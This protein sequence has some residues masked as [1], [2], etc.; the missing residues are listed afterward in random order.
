MVAHFVQVVTNHERNSRPDVASSFNFAGFCLIL[1]L[2]VGV[3]IPANLLTHIT[4]F[5]HIQRSHSNVT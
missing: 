4:L 3:W 5:H 2:I 1:L